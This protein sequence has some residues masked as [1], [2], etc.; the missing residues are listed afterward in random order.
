MHLQRIVL[1]SGKVTWTAYGG[2]A[3]IPVIR[4]FVTYLEARHYAPR[5]VSHYAR[6][7]V[8]LGNYLAA[9]G[10]NF[11]EITATDLDRFIP[12]VATSGRKLDVQTATVIPLRPEHVEVSASLHNQIL[13]GI[14]AFY[15]CLKIRG[16]A[17]L[18]GTAE[19]PRAYAPDAYQPFLAHV[20]A[21]KPRR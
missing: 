19:R 4:D 16:P 6:H 9:L 1:P 20:A 17:A 3:V 2:D 7:V 5:T 14:K 18:F 12:A 15:A 10:K 11:R 13:F 8:R 21:R